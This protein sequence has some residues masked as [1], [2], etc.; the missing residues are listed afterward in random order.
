[1]VDGISAVDILTLPPKSDSAKYH[2]LR[3]YMQVRCWKDDNNYLIRYTGV[4]TIHNGSLFPRPQRVIHCTCKGNYVHVTD[5]DS[6]V[7]LP[8]H[9]QLAKERHAQ[10]QPTSPLV[11]D[12]EELDEIVWLSL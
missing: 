6:N 3:V 8:V 10:S 2:S 1:M 12:E 5:V 11:Q 9:I 4:G 7:Q